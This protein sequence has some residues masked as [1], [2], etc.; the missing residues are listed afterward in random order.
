MLEMLKKHFFRMLFFFSFF[1]HFKCLFGGL[2]CFFWRSFG[3][4][5]VS[6]ACW[7]HPFA[8]LWLA[9]AVCELSLLLLWCL[10]LSVGSFFY[11]WANLGAIFGCS[12]HVLPL[13]GEFRWC[14]GCGLKVLVRHFSFIEIS[15]ALPVP[16]LR[17]VFLEV[18]NR[19]PMQVKLPFSQ[20][21][22]FLGFQQRRFTCMGAHFP[23]TIELPCR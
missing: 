17:Q 22:R 10:W 2:L 21:Y 7:C 18:Q 14:W 12:F 8:R 19:A 4:S 23:A 5:V 13:L 6:L 15:N 11:F 1:C 9:W 20:K 3:A 16:M